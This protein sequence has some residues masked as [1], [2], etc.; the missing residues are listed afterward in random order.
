MN[1]ALLHD[2]DLG[3]DE[4]SG[5]GASRSL[6]LVEALHASG[7]HADADQFVFALGERVH[8]RGEEL[9]PQ[10]ARDVWRATVTRF[11]RP[12]FCELKRGR[13]S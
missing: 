5:D 10:L 7:C 4:L 3:T 12:E 1:L 9:T 13:P 6:R 11:E 8:D 2:P